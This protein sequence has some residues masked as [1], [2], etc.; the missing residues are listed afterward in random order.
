MTDLHSRC[1]LSAIYSRIE[2]VY[3]FTFLP[4]L[5]LHDCD[6]VIGLAAARIAPRDG[7]GL[8]TLEV[9]HHWKSYDSDIL[10][11]RSGAC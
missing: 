4:T 6:S 3:L 8:N 1:G 2:R 5:E 9:S 7:L 11:F 10:L